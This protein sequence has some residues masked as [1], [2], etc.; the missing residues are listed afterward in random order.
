MCTVSESG[1]LGRGLVVAAALFAVAATTVCRVSAASEKTYAQ[2]SDVFERVIGAEPPPDVA[3]SPDGRWILLT[4]LEGAPSIGEL[5]RPDIVLAQ[6]DIDPVSNSF[7]ADRTATGTAMSLIRVS[8]RKRRT[9]AAPSSGLSSPLWSPDSRHFLFRRNTASGAELWLGSVDS[10]AARVLTGP[11]LQPLHGAGVP[12]AW[13]PRGDQVVCQLIPPSRGATPREARGEGPIVQDTREV[14][15]RGFVY[16]GYLSSAHD[17]ALYEYYLTSQPVLIDIETGRQR[18]VAEPGI[19]DYLSPSPDG[20]YLLAA[21]IVRPYSRMYSDDRFPRVYEIFDSNGRQVRTVATRAMGDWGPLSN[22]WAP[23]GARRFA[24]WPG[25]PASLVYIEALDGGDPRKPAEHRDRLLLLRAPFDAAPREL[26]RTRGRMAAGPDRMQFAD[27]KQANIGWLEKGRGWIEELDFSAAR[28]RVWLVDAPERG[29]PPALLLDYRIEESY[30]ARGRPLL[31]GAP[32]SNYGLAAPALW[33]EGSRV[34]L[35]GTGGSPEGD[36]PFLDRVDIR[37]GKTR[38]LFRSDRDHFETVIAVLNKSQ[39]LTRRESPFEPPN[40]YLLDLASGRCEALTDMR[41]PA[42]ELAT[43]TPQRIHYTRKDGVPLSGTLYLPPGRRPGER[44]P[45]VLWVYPIS[46]ADLAAASEVRRSSYR[47]EWDPAPR[48]FLAIR[49]LV[50]KGYAVLWYPGLPVIAGHPSESAVQQ[51]VAGAEAAVDRLVALGVA[52]RQRIAV[53]GHSHGGIVTGM[54]LAQSKLFAAGVAIAGGYNLTN[55]PLGFHAE[56]R[57]LWQAPEVYLEYSA[58][59]HADRVEAP[60]LLIH[61]TKDDTYLTLPGESER[62]FQALNGL[63]RKARLVMLPHE[64]HSPIARESIMHVAR[65]TLQWLDRHV[66]ERP[67]TAD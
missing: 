45:T 65:E 47:F 31:R 13:M 36:R 48:F 33:Q 16:A 32:A 38:R 57:T 37:S 67:A 46:Y 6:Y 62:M 5:A 28:K 23:P 7:H 20:A 50:A 55:H 18:P 56:P 42:P 25:E 30:T 17:D 44:V 52:D 22:G 64:G 34:Y 3:V 26:L 41:H 29:S 66:K 15:S 59:I 24:W 9:L 49:L 58:L 19:Y 8:D 14:E 12:C 1:R 4:S 35:T 54:L 61:G 40:Y 39:A 53:A 21:R 11:V 51:I 10:P 2:L 43:V 60:L 27:E 63:G